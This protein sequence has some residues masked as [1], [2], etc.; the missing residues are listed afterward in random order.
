[1]QTSWSERQKKVALL[2]WSNQEVGW[3]LDDCKELQNAL[4]KCLE[5]INFQTGSNVPYEEYDEV[6]T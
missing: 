3:W 4:V 5:Q 6:P 2:F 1:M